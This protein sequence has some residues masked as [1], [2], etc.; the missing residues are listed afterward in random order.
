MGY[1][2]DIERLKY[3]IGPIPVRLVQVTCQRL[4]YAL[5]HRTQAID[6]TKISVIILRNSDFLVNRL[7]IKLIRI[8]RF[9]DIF[10]T[11]L[12]SSVPAG[13]GT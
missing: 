5:C 4:F 6:S 13:L 7:L 3:M 8:C 9:N 1:E 10:I 2:P 12:S 11:D